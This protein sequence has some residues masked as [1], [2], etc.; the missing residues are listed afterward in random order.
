METESD[1]SLLLVHDNVDEANRLVSLLRNA[2]YRVE[3]HYAGNAGDLNR[4]IQ[5][6]NWELAFVQYDAQSVP[7]K[8]VFHHVR[9]LA[10]DIPIILIID[11]HDPSL[12]VDGLK[13][14]AADVIPMDE[15]QHLIQ[16]VERTL[17]DL[18]QRRRQRYWKRRFAE[19]ENRFENL[20]SSSR[21]GIAIIQEGTYVLVNDTYA[22]CFGHHSPE[23][24]N[25][26]PVMD[27]IARADQ[28]DFR[29]FLKPL[30][31]DNALEIETIQ[32]E[33]VAADG[34]QFPLRAALSQVDF[35]GEPALQLLVK[36]EFFGHHQRPEGSDTPYTEILLETDS[37]KI[38]L[39]E[40]LESIN[41][42]IR[43]SARSG[44]DML[45][46]YLQLDQHDVLQK[47][48]GIKTTEEGITQL[49]HYLEKQVQDAVSFG[50]IREDAFIM[51]G[52][53][54]DT[55]DSL[56]FCRRLLDAVASQLFDT[57]DGSFSCTM[58]IGIAAINENS[59]SADG[60]LEHCLEA[61]TAL[62]KPGSPGGNNAGFHEPVYAISSPEMSSGELAAI[63]RQLISKDK[64]DLLFQPIISLQ[65]SA[66]EFYEVRMDI[67]SDAFTD[68]KPD[69]FLHRLFA[70]EVG[71]DLDRRVIEK[72]LKRMEIQLKKAP[73]TRLFLSLNEAT[74]ADGQFLPW[75]KNLLGN[76]PVPPHSLVFQL[77]E[78]D[79]GR[80][81]GRAAT[82][83]DGLRQL[84]AKTALTH[85]GL[86]INP[87]AML[88][89]LSV[90]FVKIDGLLVEK[91]QKGSEA[92]Q[93]L[94]AMIESLKSEGQQVI[95]PHIETAA[96]IP[97]LWKARADLIQGHYVQAAQGEMNYDFSG[98]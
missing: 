79:I 47:K 34:S 22:E 97:T 82:L 90:N 81:L 68:A 52:K 16:V 14:G 63:G 55:E 38:R 3:P 42:A 31:E 64:V 5:E 40:M 53:R 86:A 77:R 48:L 35:H 33:G 56:A 39:N 13:M 98:E 54:M 92:L 67:K 93:N 32:F 80:Q 15:D 69:D 7:A 20:I 66:D 28:F 96:I 94:T 61:I 4:K 27:S 71:R 85:F 76:T 57:G 12:I 50:R 78:I 74:I 18:E 62:H 75:L 59:T 51:I 26:L 65:G 49:A 88:N 45:L 58:S 2:N 9:R 30:S 43:R 1:I 60:C 91:T 83:M 73:K 46:Y 23:D 11:Q 24:M 8:T 19:S 44:E 36:K 87:M 37:S 72:A 29:K 25:L 10:K 84:Q 6:R 89:K 70:T 95:V 21:D 17:H 41:S